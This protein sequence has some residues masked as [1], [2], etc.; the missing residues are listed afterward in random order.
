MAAQSATLNGGW[1][2]FRAVSGD[3]A[4]AN[5]A[6]TDLINILDTIEVPIVVLRRDLMIAGF[7]KAAADALRLS[8]SDI[9]RASRDISVLAGL[10]GL[11]EQCSQVIASGVE[12][13]TDFRDG[14]KWFVMRISPYTQGE[15]RVSGA[16][17]TFTNVTAFRACIDQVT[18]ER[19]CAKA[20]LN[21]VADPIAVLNA[22]QRIHSGN[23]AFYTLF[24]E[25]AS[26]RTKLKAI[27][28]GSRAFQ[29]VEVDHVFPGEGQRTPH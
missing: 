11:E 3:G 24:L 17:L 5:V 18:Y 28:A 26:L 29:P 2:D 23:R 20:I 9:G 15:R 14:D 8:P 27:L 16:V 12:S 4:A 6:A 7:N 1:S 25:L 10:P 19:E 21:T 22:D 13:R